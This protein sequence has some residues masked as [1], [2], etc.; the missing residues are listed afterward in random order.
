MRFSSLAILAS[1][2]L[3]LGTVDL[4]AQS[5]RGSSEPAEFPPT[6]FQGR[7]YVDSAGCV[8]VRAGV[9]GNVTWVPRMTRGRDHL[10]GFQ[11]S[12][13]PSV[14]A[15]APAPAQPVAQAAPRTQPAAPA[16]R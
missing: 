15:A 13:A 2:V 4:S 5:L 12:L 7:Q 10:C 1:T 3:L 14:Q 11:P 8:F 16:P 6:S 9:A